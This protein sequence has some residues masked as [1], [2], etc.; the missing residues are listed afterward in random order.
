MT[1][2]RPLSDWRRLRAP[3]RAGALAAGLALAVL[4]LAACG[5]GNHGAPATQVVARVNTGEITVHQ[6]NAALAQVP[7]VTADA[8]KAVSGRLLERL[9]DQELLVQKAE[10]AKL[11]R[12]PNVMQALEAARRSVLAS[13]WLQQSVAAVAK[14]GEAEIKSYYDQHP[15]FFSARRVFLYRSIAVQASADGV[16][17]IENQL[18]ASK[19]LDALL[20]Y[21][22]ANGLHFAD[23]EAAKSSEQLPPGVAARFAATK[24]GDVAVLPLS[25]GV[26]V[27]QIIESRAEP[28]GE[29]QARPSIEKFLF[30]QRRGERAG[31]EIKQL[32][33]AAR[34]EYTGALKAPAVAAAPAAAAPPAA[35]EV[36]KG[37]AAGIK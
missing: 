34:I 32:R 23:N 35:S 4:T 29:A 20:A 2:R 37:I 18:T 36:T 5:K 30:E 6:L 13:A 27:D 14:P 9:I 15:E 12:N 16:R 3:C 17:K 31:E 21:L 25:G 26:E 8:E 1:V 7:N 33:T 11:D 28:V 24:A 22:R 10:Q 19:D